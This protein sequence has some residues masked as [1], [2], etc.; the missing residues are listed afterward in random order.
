M[1]EIVPRIRD[2]SGR[3]NRKK[4]KKIYVEGFTRR[5]VERAIRARRLYHSLTAQ[6]VGELQVFLRQNIMRNCHVTAEDVRLAEKSSE[7]MYPP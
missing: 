4:R 2:T 5:E 1:E 6:D 7:E 3:S